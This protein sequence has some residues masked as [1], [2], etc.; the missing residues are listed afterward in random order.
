M[1]TLRTLQLDQDEFEDA[2]R[3]RADLE[4]RATLYGRA[5][6]RLPAVDVQPSDA[7]VRKD[8]QLLAHRVDVEPPDGS[9]FELEQQDAKHQANK[10][11]RP[12]LDRVRKL[13]DLHSTVPADLRG[14]SNNNNAVD[15]RPDWKAGTGGKNAAGGEA[16]SR[17]GVDGLFQPTE[18]AAAVYARTRHRLALPS[19]LLAY[20]PRSQLR[21]QRTESSSHETEE[22][23][24]AL[25]E[26]PAWCPA[27]FA[28]LGNRK[29]SN[30]L[31]KSPNSRQQRHPLRPTGSVKKPTKK[32]TPK[33]DDKCENRQ[34]A[35]LDKASNVLSRL[36]Q[37]VDRHKHPAARYSLPIEDQQHPRSYRLG[38]DPVPST[39]A[40]ASTKIGF[41]PK[42]AGCLAGFQPT[43]APAAGKVAGAK[44]RPRS[45]SI[46][47]LGRATVYCMAPSPPASPTTNAKPVGGFGGELVA[48][49]RRRTTARPQVL[50]TLAARGVFYGIALA[51]LFVRLRRETGI[52]S[53][54]QTLEDFLDACDLSL[55]QFVVGPSPS[56]SLEAARAL[57]AVSR[58][59][60]LSA[61]EPF[62]SIVATK[63]ANAFFTAVDADVR[64]HVRV[65]DLM[66]A[67]C[68][69]Q[70]R[71]DELR[72]ARMQSLG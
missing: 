41:R 6:S 28:T 66:I 49:R 53:G 31:T 8:L 42:S 22:L 16:A 13:N 63:D 71:H 56:S 64:D 61:L 12:P 52:H 24:D 44:R 29:F 5:G 68:S 39:G 59:Q 3:A 37:R 60:F 33:A 50:E 65:C 9:R 4:R 27:S 7:R 38:L 58:T 21:G 40:P 45:A 57:L 51:Q 1:A 2:E 36:K 46:T 34:H 54:Q 55:D 30:Q 67:V 15:D 10:G 69:I 47:Y 43:Q 32:E 11:W 70:R 23:H 25:P 26:S 14:N 48:E 19:A 72:R 35:L 18:G 17:T 62:A 20:P